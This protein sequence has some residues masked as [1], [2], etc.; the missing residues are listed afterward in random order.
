MILCHILDI[1]LTLNLSCVSVLPVRFQDFPP[2][3]SMSLPNHARVYSLRASVCL[4]VLGTNKKWLSCVVWCAISWSAFQRFLCGLTPTTLP[5]RQC[6]CNCVSL[7]SC[8]TFNTYLSPECIPTLLPPTSL[9]LQSSCFPFSLV[10]GCVWFCACISSYPTTLTS[11]CPSAVFVKQL[12][13]KH[14]WQ[15]YD[16]VWMC[17]WERRKRTS[18]HQ[19]IRA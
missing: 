19:F 11:P 12:K 6:C 1:F 18:I 17:V 16:Q 2:R 4:S 15:G 10:D 13:D 14:N 3:P 5:F 9:M 7:L 8:V